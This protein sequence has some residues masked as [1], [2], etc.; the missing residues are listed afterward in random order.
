MTILGRTEAV[1]SLQSGLELEAALHGPYVFRELSPF[2][3]RVHGLIG[4]ES[5][6]RDL[7]SLEAVARYAARTHLIPIDRLRTHA[8]PG[9]GNPNA[10]LM[11]V[12]EAPGEAEDRQGR[13][14]V[15]R[16][17]KLLD[18]M[19]AAIHLSRDEIFLTNILKSRPPNN[20]NPEPEEMAAHMPMLYR[21]MALVD[22]DLILCLGLVSARALLSTSEPLYKLRGKDHAFHGIRLLVT[23]HPA[24]LLR[25]PKWKRPAWEDLQHLQSL[26][27][28]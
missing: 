8:V 25:N 9:T 21:Q 2:A 17:G 14:F 7:G 23:Y 1:R 10:R 16:A 18:K 11:V 20:R 6:V 28:T 22:P 15:G 13:P 5:S 19:L 27:E 24:A 26:Y 4:S 3:E 12:G